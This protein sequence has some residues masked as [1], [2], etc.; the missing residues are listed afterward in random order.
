M[1]KIGEAE[2][3]ELDVLSDNEVDF[4]F[5]N[6]VRF[7]L[8]EHGF[9]TIIKVRTKTSMINILFDVGTSGDVVLKN[10]ELAEI[11]LKDVDYIILSHRHYD[12]VGGLLKIIDN[13]KPRIP[14]ICHP[15]IFDPSL[16]IKPFLR[17]VGPPF[18]SKQLSDRVASLLTTISPMR[19]ADGIITSGE[20][21]RVTEYEKTE[22][23]YAFD[24][25][26]QI[27]QDRLMDDSALI[28]NVKDVGLV[29][30]T[31]CGHSGLINTLRHSLEITG[32]NRIYAVIGGFHLLKSTKDVLERTFK[33]L[34][35]MGVEKIAPTHCSGVAI[36][37]LV[38]QRK[39]EMY[40]G[41][42]VGSKILI[43]NP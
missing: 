32:V 7:S 23:F 40:L 33:D 26:F 16:A 28:I 25:K 6:R 14:I 18:T 11:D 1:F 10:A 42:G 3:V 5:A 27:V 20:I 19:I 38:L 17:N 21:P 39:P 37:A 9:S 24:E 4:D 8:A 13:V 34:L 35:E 22:D 30:V 43:G 2:G 15:K 29:V 41:A 12:H 31:G 36:K